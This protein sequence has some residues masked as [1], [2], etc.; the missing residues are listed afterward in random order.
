MNFS[1][2]FMSLEGRIGRKFYW[3]GSLLLFATA[4]IVL[5]IVAGVVGF[6]N[7]IASDGRT[8]GI[9]TLVTLLILAASVPIVVK[10]L[11]DRNKSPHY[12]WLLYAPSLLSIFGDLAGV[13][14]TADAPNVLGTA[15]GVMNLAVGLW[16]LIELGFLRGSVG[17]NRF[18]PD[19]LAATR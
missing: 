14:G 17:P 8:T 19:P 10:R 12:A 15:L 5:F 4:M 3:I 6:D 13:L 9:A 1:H 2:L 7:L 16:F 11:Q 18:G